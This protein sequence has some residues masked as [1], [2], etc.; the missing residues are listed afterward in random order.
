MTCQKCQSQHAEPI[1]SWTISGRKMTV[2][3]LSMWACLNR[4]VGTSGQENSLVPLRYPL[5]F[6]P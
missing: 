6:H 1:M 3:Q 5:L 4:E 2:P